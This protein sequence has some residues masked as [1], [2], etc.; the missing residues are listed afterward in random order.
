MIYRRCF[1]C[2][3]VLVWRSIFQK[4]FDKS[5]V[6]LATRNISLPLSK[7]GSY[8]VWPCH[9]TRES[10]HDQQ[11][12][13][14][15]G[16]SNARVSMEELVRPCERMDRHDRART[17]G[18][19]NRQTNC[20]TW[21]RTTAALKFPGDWMSWRTDVGDELGMTIPCYDLWYY[22]HS[23]F[24]KLNVLDSLKCSILDLATLA[25]SIGL[26]SFA[27]LTVVMRSSLVWDACYP[28]W[29]KMPW[30]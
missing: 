20:W 30:K 7:G 14:R 3:N 2:L 25:S 4:V 23:V 9:A 8:L 1:V 27:H 18:A 17:L 22:D 12:R 6:S 13:H 15:R 29:G 10:L 5:F 26:V 21:R 28:E 11:A 19:C 16:Q 24:L